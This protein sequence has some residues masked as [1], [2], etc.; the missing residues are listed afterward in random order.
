[1]T[2]PYPV[3]LL[4]TLFAAGMLCREGPAQSI[5]PI[6]DKLVKNEKDKINK[7]KKTHPVDLE[8]GKEYLI[9]MTSKVFDSVLRVLD[10]EGKELAANDDGGA[11][12]NA[13]LGFIPKKTGKYQLVATLPGEKVLTPS[14]NE[15]WTG[16]Y[17][18]NVQA[19]QKVGKADVENG[20]I[21]NQSPKPGKPFPYQTVKKK[22]D[23][24]KIYKIDLES[25]DFDPAL[26]IYTAKG[27]PLGGDQDGGG[28]KNAQFYFI[29]PEGGDYEIRAVVQ[30]KLPLAKGEK[31]PSGEF[32]LTIQQYEVA[33]ANGTTPEK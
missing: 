6:K 24:G 5:E 12:N 26:V 27:K 23:K 25:K 11:G 10:A 22:L 30:V 9:D 28:G 20:K 3:L 21:E 13:R 15:K 31:V 2:R 17:E 29:P 18:I 33:K 16:A 19:I 7:L 14:P 1:M 8:E 4:L 32:T